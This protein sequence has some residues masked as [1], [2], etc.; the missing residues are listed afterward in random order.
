MAKVTESSEGRAIGTRGRLTLWEIELAMAVNWVNVSTWSGFSLW[1]Q[2]C[3]SAEPFEIIRQSSERE[4]RSR[5]FG[6][7]CEN[8]AI[9]QSCR[10]GSFEGE[11]CGDKMT[12]M[13][14][15]KRGKLLSG[16]PALKQ[17]D[18]SSRCLSPKG[19]ESVGKSRSILEP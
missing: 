13:N 12:V 4:N 8:S 7:N 19:M 3:R 16:S 17:T 2:I 6:E 14:G 5:S 1:N 10:S 11:N 15:P 9:R 18:D